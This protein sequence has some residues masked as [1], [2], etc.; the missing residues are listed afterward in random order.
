MRLP[1]LEKLLRVA[2]LAAAVAA[3]GAGF[4]L[5]LAYLGYSCHNYAPEFPN[6]EVG[7]YLQARA[8]A[9]HGFDSGYFGVME[10]RAPASFSQMGVHG[11][12]FPVLYGGLG[13]VFGLS[14]CTA[15]VFNVAAVTAALAIYLF[16]AR[17]TNG[18]ALLIPLFFLSFWPYYE[19][20]YSWLQESLHYAIAIVLAGVFAALIAGS[21]LA[22]K[23]AFR[24][25]VYLFLGAASLLRISWALMFVPLLVLYHYRRGSVAS[26]VRALL[27]S[28]A[29][30]LAL[31]IVYRWLCAPY[32]AIKDAF[33]MNKALTLDVDL[34]T[35]GAHVRH[36]LS[37]VVDTLWTGDAVSRTTVWEH[38]LI[39][40]AVLAAAAVVALRRRVSAGRG[41]TPAPPRSH[42][43]LWIIA[44]NVGV[45]TVATI[46]TY[47]IG[48]GGAPRIFSVHLLL[49]L[50]LALAAPG[51][52]ARGLVLSI[53]LIN[54]AVGA[55]A[56][57]HL[58]E[59]YAYSFSNRPR[60]VA[61]HDRVQDVLVYEPGANG[62]A[63]TVLTDRLPGAFAGMP[64]GI[65]CEYYISDTF[66]ARQPKSRYI[67]ATPECILYCGQYY[68][69][70]VHFLR[71]LEDMP[72]ERLVAPHPANLYLNLAPAAPDSVR[73]HRR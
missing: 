60:A 72:G 3:P 50:M 53:L 42:A 55:A 65:G 13:R 16:L 35:L 17:P 30:I 36:N 21:P 20:V 54:L 8:F 40:A 46:L 66:L 34:R 24:W 49:T 31:M 33:L 45:I 56:L 11:P 58:H 37:D 61:F 44:Y 14:C 64:E 19:H 63:N 69:L 70:K 59:H 6:D 28:G 10:E 4:G 47:A 41:S 7:Y 2:C 9:T 57:D 39:L 48:N 1:V 52:F 32:R 12:V 25:A 27:A 29:T 26:L 67:V 23:P 73:P 68:G 5:V 15:F 71:S 43:F 22:R 38:W 18:Q 62:W 51:W